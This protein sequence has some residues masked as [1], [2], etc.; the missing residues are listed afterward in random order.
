MMLTIRPGSPAFDEACG[1]WA[2]RQPQ[3]PPASTRPASRRPSSPVRELISCRLRKPADVILAGTGT[4]RAAPIPGRTTVPVFRELVIADDAGTVGAAGTA[5]AA[6]GS[7]FEYGMSGKW[8]ELLKQIAP[9]VTRAAVLRDPTIA[10]GIAASSPP[11]KL[12]HHRS[13]WI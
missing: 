6:T 12:S 5:V 1:N 8:L 3:H 9:A 4:Q 2:E 13:R 10:S 7:D 11:C